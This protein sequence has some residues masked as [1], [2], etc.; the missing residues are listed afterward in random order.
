MNLKDHNP[1]KTVDNVGIMLYYRYSLKTECAI[2]VDPDL[3]I[4]RLC[5]VYKKDWNAL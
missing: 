2:N 5:S 3:Y 4:C 1:S